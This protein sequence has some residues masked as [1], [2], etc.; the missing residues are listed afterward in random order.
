MDLVLHTILPFVGVLVALIVFHELGH[1]ITAKMTGV[2]VLEAGL[3]Y[4]P[5]LWGF[6]WR[7]TIYSI[8]W[9]PLGGFVRLLGEEDPSDP[10]SLAAK[11]RWVRLLV[12]ASGSG[13]NFL[14]P[15][16]LF[17]LVFM[18]PRDVS[19][20]LTQIT[21]VVRE[22]PA[23]VARAVSPPEG[24][25]PEEAEGMEPGDIILA[26]N[27]HETRNPG[28]VGKQIRLNLGETLTMTV[29]RTL[30]D[31]EVVVLDYRME[32]R[33]AAD[34]LVYTIQEGD[35]LSSIAGE[36][37]VLPGAIVAAADIDT[38][39]DEGQE[40]AIPVGDETVSYTVQENDSVALVARRLSVSSDDVREAAGLPD[41]DEA[42][43]PGEELR[44]GQGPT[45][46]TIAVWNPAFVESE[47]FPV[48]EAFP[49]S[50]SEYADTLVLFRNEVLSWFRGGR[51]PDVTGPVGIAQVTGEVVEESGWQA[52]LELA[53]LLS[54][55]LGIV[56]MLPLPMLDGGRVAFVLLEIVRRG[57]RIAPEKEAIVHLVG[58]AL[59]ISLAVVVTYFDVAR[60]VSGDS[61]FR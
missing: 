27:G 20:G 1:Y 14:L 22:A 24:L 26:V 42:L 43:V 51:T 29:R 16:A 13:M 55:N 3:G 37:G 45:G 60:L 59:I 19:T 17:T 36:L 41:P 53:A 57:R 35:T 23:D 15:I 47:S 39:L 52:L 5:R 9:L 12:L 38:E 10:E 30:D 7:D 54:F 4:P 49:K 44:F 46:I 18:L 56:N 33:W 31:G 11:P 28:E 25:D 2:K 6:T 34:D 40:L 8:N 50:F 58:L 48:W 61:L 21:S 32:S